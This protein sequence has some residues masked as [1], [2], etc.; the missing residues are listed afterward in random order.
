MVAPWVIYAMQVFL[1]SSRE[2]KIFF[3]TAAL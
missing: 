1:G 3:T 2:K